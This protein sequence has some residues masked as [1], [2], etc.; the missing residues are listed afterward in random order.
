VMNEDLALLPAD[1]IKKYLTRRQQDLEVCQQALASR[2]FS[3]LEM[4]GHKIK[5]NGASF[6]YPELSQLGEVLEESAKCQNQTLAEESIRRFKDWMSH[7]HEAKE[8]T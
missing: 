5:G 6:G 1:A 3:R 2:D 8:N 7:Q 4:V